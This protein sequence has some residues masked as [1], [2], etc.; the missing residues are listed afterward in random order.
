MKDR[1]CTRNA[2]PSPSATLKK[3]IHDRIAAMTRKPDVTY[4]DAF[5]PMP[6]PK[7][8]AI[9]KPISGRKTMA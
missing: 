6:S 3:T 8:P 9:K 2:S 4:S 5:A 7:R 1:T